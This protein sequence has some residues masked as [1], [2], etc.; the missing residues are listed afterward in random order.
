MEPIHV[1]TIDGELTLKDSPWDPVARYLPMVG[2][3]TATLV[4]HQMKARQITNAGALDAD[5]FWPYADVIGG[6]RWPGTN[7]GPKRD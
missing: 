2:A 4:T 5:R 3:A 6:S 1:E 7:G